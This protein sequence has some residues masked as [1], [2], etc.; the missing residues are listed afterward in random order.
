M[1]LS[2][3]DVFPMKTE[4]K[5][6]ILFFGDSL[7]L[8]LSLGATLLLGFG[9]SLSSTTLA[10]HVI[11]FAPLYIVW[12]LLNYVFELYDLINQRTPEDILLRILRAG[13][14]HLLVA[15]AFF[16]VMPLGSLTPKT[17]LVIHVLGF[18]ALMLILRLLIHRTARRQSLRVALLDPKNELTDIESELRSSP[19][20]GLSNITRLISVPDLQQARQ[21]DV[22][23]YGHTA[24]DSQGPAALH[25]LPAWTMSACQAYERFFNRIPLSHV[26]PR[27]AIEHL[28]RRPSMHYRIL[29]VTMYRSIAALV[30]IATL[31][32][33]VL[34]AV[35]IYIEDRGPIIFRQKRIGLRGQPIIIYKLRTMSAAASS[36]KAYWPSAS[37][38]DSRITRVGTLLR[39]LHIDELP[40]MFN[41]I[42]GDLALIGPRAEAYDYYETFL[43]EIPYYYIRH[44]IKPGFTGWAQVRYFYSHGVAETARKFEYDLYY[45]KNQSVWLDLSILLR[46]MYIIL[47]H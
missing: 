6:I 3:L 46:T 11:A 44:T 38:R 5:K 27:W 10:E 17:N 13:L 19:Q 39:K 16:Y 25:Q 29:D 2:I 36:K 43:R 14:A 20:I 18:A 15:I 40:Q 4:L 23:L 31:P 42:R 45:I 32:I 28:N 30:L 8:A 35:A 22:L 12:L 24:L 37:A 34:A 26:T 7:A 41:V 9:N 33:T 21:Y 47:K 1:L